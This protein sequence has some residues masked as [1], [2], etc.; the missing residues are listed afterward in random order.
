MNKETYE[1]ITGK[2]S[3]YLSES[4]FII[5]LLAAICF[6]LVLILNRVNSVYGSIA[7]YSAIILYVFFYLFRL[8][9]EE[10]RR[11][12]ITKNKLRE[13]LMDNK[14]DKEDR[15]KIKI[16]LDSI[17]ISKL[18]WNLII[19]MILSVIA[20]AIQIYMDLA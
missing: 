19:L 4:F 8:Y 13:K 5:G 3:R 11:K 6:R 7:W 9:I 2:N 1:G 15:K 20:L 18:R 14:C 10:K 17:L 16:L 12:L